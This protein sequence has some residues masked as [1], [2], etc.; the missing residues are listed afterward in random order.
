MNTSVFHIKQREGA[1][2]VDLEVSDGGEAGLM[3]GIGP[4]VVMT[5]PRVA[6]RA[7]EQYQEAQQFYMHLEKQ[8][9]TIGFGFAG[10][11]INGH[12]I[13]RICY[14]VLSAG[15]TMATLGLELYGK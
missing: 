10:I 12:L 13:A 8:S 15:F 4:P 11:V 5:T 7:P 9:K 14:G 6:V 2:R 1:R 3:N